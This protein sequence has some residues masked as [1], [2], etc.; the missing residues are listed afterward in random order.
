MSVTVRILGDDSDLQRKLADSANALA[1]WSL[2]A[3]T[4]AA[5]GATALTKKTAE[6]AREIKNLSNLI[7]TSTADFQKMAAGAKTVGIEQDKLA[8]IFKDVNDK[9]GDFMQTGAGPLADFF[10]NIAPKVGVTADQ[11]KNLSGPQAMQAYVNALEKA[12]VSQAEMTFYMEAIAS[13]ASL[14]TPLLRDNGNEFKKLGDEAAR[15][16]AILSDIEIEQL[17]QL[18]KKIIE[19]E[20]SFEAMANKISVKLAPQIT[21]MI[22]L[23]NEFAMSSDELG[24]T[25]DEA[26]DGIVSAAGFVGDS[27]RG[28]EVV[29]KTLQAGVT[30]SLSGLIGIVGLFNDDFEEMSNSMAKDAEEAWSKVHSTLMKPLPSES[31]KKFTDEVQAQSEKAAKVI[32]EANELKNESNIVQ[33]DTELMQ[34]AEKFNRMLE[35][36]QAYQE[37]SKE[38]LDAF[39]ANNLKTV[40]D[41]ARA[42]EALER[43]SNARKLGMASQMMGNLSSLM[44][45]ENRKLFNIGKIAA[46][47]QAVIDGY[48][49]VLS[50]Y[51]EGTKI[52]GPPVGAAFAATA[53]IAAGVQIAKISSASYG[54]RGGSAAMPSGG[55]GT[56]A[57]SQQ[58][59]QPAAEPARTVRVDTLDPT[60]LVSG[61]VINKLAEQLAEYQEDGFKLV[62]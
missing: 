17:E 23:F 13:D 62:V 36:E 56:P 18:N 47:S 57:E 1:K 22:D 33:I 32:T 31:I 41:Y 15:S 55:G 14:L 54:N 49:A 42:T 43:A 60:A 10:E 48:S 35:A 26:F 21:G 25:V 4:A 59:A 40:E 20:Q 6:T 7:G 3:G 34:Q 61:A 2:A 29:F 5:A 16:G 28:L 12:S 37:A 51:R 53:A 38:G 44:D 45:T 9:I 8:D 19:G 50:S 27:F 24:N 58:Q 46:L 11:F 52:G 39:N 30:Q